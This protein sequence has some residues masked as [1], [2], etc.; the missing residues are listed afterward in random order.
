MVLLE[1]GCSL[2]VCRADQGPPSV[3]GSWEW[4][5]STPHR[6]CWVPGETL[7][8]REGETKSKVA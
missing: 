8:D 3:V 2:R 5:D 1:Q 6:Q 4:S 7:K